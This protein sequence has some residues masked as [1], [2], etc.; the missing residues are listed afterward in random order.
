MS[1]CNQFIFTDCDLDGAGA[2]AVY[3]WLT[4]ITN[5]PYKVCRVNDLLTAVKSF[6]K[7]H[8][9]EDYD[10]VLFFDLDAS[11]PELKEI[12]D[13][14]NVVIV[15]HHASNISSPTTYDKATSY[16]EDCTSTC[17]LIYKHFLPKDL[18]LSG[19][20]KLFIA[21]VDDYDSYELKTPY[22]K[23]LNSVFW[24]YK[25]DRLQKLYRD[26][27]EGFTGFNKFHKNML[28]IKHKDLTQLKE[29]LE[30]YT[31]DV[32]TKKHKFRLASTVATRHINDVADYISEKA[33]AEVAVV[34]NTNS[35]KVSFRRRRG[36]EDVSM[37]KLA[38]AVTE[39]SGGH[40]AAAGGML[41]DKFLQ[42]TKTLKPESI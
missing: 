13:H 19:P 9:F 3:S 29:E 24:S 15:D 36:C 30:I 17:K 21:L 1:T 27:P 34:V 42:F 23:D 16:V 26:F 40:E 22:S 11:D 31:G 28:D 10:K 8:K 2:Y 18:K 12:I 7:T 14:D 37:V 33:G 5:I 41:C 25:G 32:T 20:Q 39:N 6:N 35:G 4:G 38:A